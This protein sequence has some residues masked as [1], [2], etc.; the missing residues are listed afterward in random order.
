MELLIYPI[1]SECNAFS[2]Y[3]TFKDPN[4]LNTYKKLYVKLQG[5][6]SNLQ[7]IG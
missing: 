6:D 1:S 7:Q 2:T 5:Q 4:S 3:L